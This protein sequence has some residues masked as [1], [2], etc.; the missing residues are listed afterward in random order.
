M[1]AFDSQRMSSPFTIFLAALAIRLAAVWFLGHYQQP[2]LWENGVIARYLLDGCGFCMDFSLPAEPSS[3]QAPAYPAL[4]FAAWRGLG[5]GPPAYFTISVLQALALASMVFPVGFLTRRWFGERP[6][7]W[8]MWLTAVMPLYVWYGTRLHQAGFVMATHPWLLR[9]WVELGE[10]PGTARGLLAGAAAGVA[11]L[12]QP[13]LLLLSL[14]FGIAQGV[15][16]LRAR[17]RDL[18]AALSWSAVAAVLVLMPWTIRNYHVHGRVVPIRDSFGKELWM[19]NNPYA[20]GTSFDVGGLTEITYA[21]PPKAFALKG[22]VPEADLMDAMKA[23]AIAYIRDDPWAFTR[24]TVKKIGWFWTAAPAERVRHTQ[25]GEA[26]QFRWLHLSSWFGFVVL[27][28][29]GAWSARCIPRSYLV[30]VGLYVCVYSALYGVTHV[31]QAR[32]RGEMEFIFIPLAA[33][34]LATLASSTRNTVWNLRG[35]PVSNG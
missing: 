20:T 1:S 14:S 8:A 23:E 18:L 4:I 35:E 32:Y 15:R 34:G 6:A 17:R 33:V 25:G 22:H 3:W 31:G 13:I 30:V 10:R 27:A 2:T 11:A 26:I 5:V 7:V 24:R 16:A 19:G 12:L 21:H 28:A 9:W 29:A